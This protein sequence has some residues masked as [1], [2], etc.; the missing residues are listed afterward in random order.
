MYCFIL[1]GVLL[2]NI[3]M[4]RATEYECSF[5]CVAH[6]NCNNSVEQSG[7]V[8]LLGKTS[9]CNSKPAEERCRGPH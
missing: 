5:T 4:S 2:V 9:P 1:C 8:M 3:F 7:A 6:C